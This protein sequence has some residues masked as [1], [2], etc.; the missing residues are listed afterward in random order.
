MYPIAIR[1]R[2]GDAGQLHAPGNPSIARRFHFWRG[3]SGQ[4]YACTVFAGEPVPA[5]ERYVA[6][7]VRKEGTTRAVIAVDG[8]MRHATVPTSFDEIHIHLVEDDDALASTARDLAVLAE[9]RAHEIG[10]FSS[11]PVY[12]VGKQL[13]PRGTIQLRTVALFKQAANHSNVAS[14]IP[15]VSS[16]FTV[17]S[18]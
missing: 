6:L 14:R 13:E 4:R 8:S 5:Y 7:Y 9:P 11:L 17:A 15:S 12:A 16:S 1:P 2:A 18:T 3:E 10:T